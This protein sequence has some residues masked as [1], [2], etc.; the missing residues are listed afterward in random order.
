MTSAAVE[1]PDAPSIPYVPEIPVEFAKFLEKSSSKRKRANEAIPT[2]E[3]LIFLATRTEVDALEFVAKELG[4]EFR[5]CHD[6][7]GNFKYFNLGKIGADRVVA[8]Q[9]TMGPLSESGSAALAIQYRS[10][11]GANAI[12]SLGMAFGAMP[13]FQRIGDVLVATGILPYDY[14]LVKTA[15]NGSP[16]V[17]YGDVAVFRSNPELLNRFRR[18][19]QAAEW[20]DLV[21]HG[22]FLSGA[23]RI[24]CAS[25]RDELA[26]ECGHGK[27]ELVVGGD[28]EGVGFLSASERERPCW[29]VVKGISDFADINRTE[30][31]IKQTRPIACYR[32]AKFVLSTLLATEL[33]EGEDG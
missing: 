7:V 3:K 24:H 25:Y 12:I 28:M 9:T 6:K 31:L 5:P 1:P 16:I 32:A 23:A 4:T 19:S 11:T 20:K 33:P 18:T 17:D 14:K 15:D 13:K 22:L 27:G 29:I 21:R 8:V 2:C 30:E 10:R 26:K